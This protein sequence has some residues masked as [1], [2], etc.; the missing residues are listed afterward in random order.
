MGNGAALG[1]GLAI[2]AL[3]VADAV[4]LDLGLPVIVLAGLDRAI[5]AVAV[6]R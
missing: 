4:W 1:L 5:E 2:V 6:W 3:F